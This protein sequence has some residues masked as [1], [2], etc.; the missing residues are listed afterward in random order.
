MRPPVHTLCLALLTALAVLIPASAASARST[1]VMV[2]AAKPALAATVTRCQA[3]TDPTAGGRATFVGA[4][5]AIPGSARMEM[6]FELQRAVTAAEG[7]TGMDV[8]KFS[9]WLAAKKGRTGFVYKKKVVGLIGPAAYRV[10][11]TFRWRNARGKVIRMV[12]RTSK[13]CKQAD[14]RPDLT[15]GAV[16]AAAGEKGSALYRIV[17]RNTGRTA[18]GTFAVSLGTGAN[19]GGAAATVS[20]TVPGVAAKS[21]KTAFIPAARCAPGTSIDIAVDPANAVVERDETNNTRSVPCPFT[22]R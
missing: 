16:T 7:Y 17:V 13:A 14:L 12:K 8:P 6:R 1:R 11:V 21:R 15:I 18:A 10:V 19:G 4:M 5:P 22:T 20:A 3:A 2:V 9:Q